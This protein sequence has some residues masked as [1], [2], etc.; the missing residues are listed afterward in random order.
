MIGEVVSHYRILAKLGGGGMG[1]V[2]EAEDAHLRRNVALKFLP[3]DVGKSP[4][5]LERR[6]S[7]GRLFN[8]ADA[9]RDFQSRAMAFRRP[10]QQR[11]PRCRLPRGQCLRRVGAI[12]QKVGA[13]EG[14]HMVRDLRAIHPHAVDGAERQARQMHG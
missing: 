10:V 13:A 9:G 4:E 6:Q 14:Q 3:D 11:I 5:A 2:Y 8:M 7:L 12:G 1:V